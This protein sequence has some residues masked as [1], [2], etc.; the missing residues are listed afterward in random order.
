M[1]GFSIN[2]LPTIS[3]YCSARIL[4]SDGLTNSM[5][6]SVFKIK[7]PSLMLVKAVISLLFSFCWPDGFAF[8]VHPPDSWCYPPVS[9]FHRRCKIMLPWGSPGEASVNLSI[10]RIGSASLQKSATSKAIIA[11]MQMASNI[12]MNFSTRDC[13][14]WSGRAS[15]T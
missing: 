14:S 4:P 13:T 11:T 1:K 12:S 6:A 2:V 8:A 5:V 7:T 9:L 15:L 10:I 3:P